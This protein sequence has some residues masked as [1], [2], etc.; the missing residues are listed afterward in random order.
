M[1]FSVEALLLLL[2]PVPAHVSFVRRRRLRQRGLGIG[3]STISGRQTAQG[4]W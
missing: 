2:Q 4:C 1:Y 3:E